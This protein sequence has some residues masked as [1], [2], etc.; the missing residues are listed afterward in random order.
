[1]TTAEALAE[2]MEA[3]TT[4]EASAR[5]EFPGASEEQIY[6][7]TKGAMNHALRIDARPQPTKE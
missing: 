4:I 5:A 6:Q 1:M 3:W 2:L 7:I